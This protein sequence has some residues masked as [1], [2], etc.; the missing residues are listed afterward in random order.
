MSGHNIDVFSSGMVYVDPKNLNY[1]PYWQ[2]WISLRTSKLEQD[3]L[4]NLYKKYTIP[5]IDLVIFV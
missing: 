3:L 1:D 2:K 5:C 4:Q